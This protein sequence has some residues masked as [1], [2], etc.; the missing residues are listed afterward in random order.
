KYP[1]LHSQ[2]IQQIIGEFL[3]A[4][5]SAR[6]LRRNGIDADYPYNKSRFRDVV[7]TNQGARIR[8][9]YLILPNGKAGSLRIKIPETVRLPGRLMEVRL[10]LFNVTLICEV[11]DENKT[12]ASEIGVD[13]G[14]NSLIAATD[15]E[16]A[17][18]ISGRALKS[19]VRNRN[20][21]VA[22]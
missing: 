8:D 14:V 10:G 4:V 12:V 18:I 2:T 6:Q 19:E 13:L 7:Y 20:R 11:A 21:R 3:E 17:V 1:N 9:N 15:G 22:Q 5:N 16:K